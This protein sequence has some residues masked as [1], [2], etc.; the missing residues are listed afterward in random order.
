MSGQPQDSRHVQSLG[1][2]V[3]LPC[4]RRGLQRQISALAEYWRRYFGGIGGRHVVGL[5]LAGFVGCVLS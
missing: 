1:T 2:T 5:G 3:C 4:M